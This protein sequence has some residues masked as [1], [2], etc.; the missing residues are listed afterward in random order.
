MN[1]SATA[2]S[3][4]DAASPH[5]GYR[6]VVTAAVA[7][8]AVFFAL[9]AW[10]ARHIDWNAMRLAPAAALLRV[11]TIYPATDTGVVTGHIYTPLGALAFSPIAW[12]PDIS[13]MMSAGSLLALG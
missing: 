3:S 4:R 10:Y 2:M 7:F 12:L 11:E 1:E 13:T 6:W 9:S 5:R 8:A